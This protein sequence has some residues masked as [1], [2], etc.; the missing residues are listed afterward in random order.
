[1]YKLIQI[2]ETSQNTY[3]TLDGSGL[4]VAVG[5]G[6]QRSAELALTASGNTTSLCKVLLSLLLSDL[7]LLFLT[8]AA[9]LVWLEGVLGLERGP[10]VLGDISVR[11]D[12]LYCG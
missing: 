7:D 1:M 11:H 10:A 5:S 4:I 12:D 8:A 6:A 3:L 9:E 2:Y